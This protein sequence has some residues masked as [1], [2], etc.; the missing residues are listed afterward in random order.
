LQRRRKLMLLE[1]GV[2]RAHGC[3]VFGLNEIVSREVNLTGY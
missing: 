3:D 1:W 2:G